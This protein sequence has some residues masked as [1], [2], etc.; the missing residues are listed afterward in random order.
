MTINTC[1]IRSKSG[2][3]ALRMGSM[4]LGLAIFVA[5]CGGPTAPAPSVGHPVEDRCVSQ[6]GGNRLFISDSI[7][8]DKTSNE[9][10]RREYSYLAE[11]IGAEPFWCGTQSSEAYRFFLLPT[12]APAL[13][14][15]A[16]RGAEGW[17]FI[18]AEFASRT[19]GH[20][21][22]TDGFVL[23]RKTER[24]VDETTAGELLNALDAA[25]FW[26]TPLFFTMGGADGSSWSIEGRRNGKYRIVTRVN[27]DE[28]F[29][30]AARIFVRLSG[31][32][33]PS[34]MKPR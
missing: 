24:A 7:A 20:P 4:A 22:I 27:G 25:T 26:N 15:T 17:T 13:V 11:Q 16:T 30:K 5:G 9:W 8:T 21:K 28:M 19:P 18:G 32:E 2:A 29:Q 23:S 12:F 33:V 14:V 34:G 1:G 31:L 10:L 6:A 3:V